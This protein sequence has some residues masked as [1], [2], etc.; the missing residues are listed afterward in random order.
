M[1]QLF[2]QAARELGGFG[3]WL[4]GFRLMW[5]PGLRR[6]TLVPLLI[7]V[8]LF[9]AAGWLLL[10]Y[11]GDWLEGLLP[12]W[13]D[14]LY[15]VLMPVLVLG[16][17]VVTFFTFT[18]VANLVAAPFNAVL[19][20]RVEAHLTGR[21]PPDD[22]TGILAGAA[23]AVAGEVGRLLYLF[24]WA[25]PL[26]ILWF[27]PGLNLLA[28]FA[29]FAFSAWM[30][31]LEYVDNP[32]GNHG[33][34]FREQRR[35]L[36]QRPALTLGFG[37]LMTLMTMVPVANFLAMPVGVCGATRMWVEGFADREGARRG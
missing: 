9:A 19:A 25:V 30:M 33:L 23:K 20:A 17:L 2:R 34:S 21:L 27:I 1:T 35:R 16:L 8:L 10:E 15:W 37:S 22:E 7:N 18:L 11:A 14:F 31:S 28:P 29:W 3:Y 32:A 36:R 12:G 24:A 6:F 26:V 4:G 13:L 5:T